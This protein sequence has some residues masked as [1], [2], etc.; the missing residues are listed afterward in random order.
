VA[1]ISAFISLRCKGVSAFFKMAA[2]ASARVGCPAF[3]ALFAFFLAAGFFW[4]SSLS[5]F[6]GFARLRSQ[7]T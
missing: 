3:A 2:I 1:A 7:K 4:A 6:V 5:A